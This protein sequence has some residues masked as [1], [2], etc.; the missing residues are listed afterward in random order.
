MKFQQKTIIKIFAGAVIAS[1]IFIISVIIHVRTANLNKIYS[2]ENAPSADAIII[3]GASLKPD[4]NPSD[5]LNDRLIVGADLFKQGKAGKLIVSGDDGQNRTDEVSV[6]KQKLLELGVPEDSI[7]K[8]D[9]GYRTYES[10]K[11]AKN[12]FNIDSAI[13][14]TQKFHLVRALYVCN[15]LDVNSVG[16]ASDL[17]SYQ[18]INQFIIRDWLASFKAWIDLNLLEPKPPVLFS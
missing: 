1:A 17:Q 14:V 8:D 4:G 12:V 16:V 3:L 6:M 18:K 10:C 2:T 9:H 11:R 7:I 13:L 5:A 15:E